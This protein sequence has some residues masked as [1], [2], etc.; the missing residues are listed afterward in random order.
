MIDFAAV[1]LDEAIVLFEGLGKRAQTGLN[2]A[3]LTRATS[4]QERFTGATPRRR[5]DTAEGW[6]VED[7]GIIAGFATVAVV[8]RVQT[9]L[10]FLIASALITGTGRRGASAT[11]AR[12]YGG[13]FAATPGMLPS[14]PLQTAWNEESIRPLDDVAFVKAL[15][16]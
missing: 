4:V 11:P 15:G 5:G 8:N 13:G 16:I 9:P 14:L 2:T 1:G 7:Q 10:G 3:L 12:G 6:K